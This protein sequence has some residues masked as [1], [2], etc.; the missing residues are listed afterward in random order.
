MGLN[1]LPVLLLLLITLQ[2]LETIHLFSLLLQHA[3]IEALGQSDE[4]GGV[5]VSL[6]GD[7]LLEERPVQLG[8]TIQV[9]ELYFLGILEFYALLGTQALCRGVVQFELGGYFVEPII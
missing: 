9:L 3:F 6:F 2:H 8:V 1:C 4:V 5:E 7:F